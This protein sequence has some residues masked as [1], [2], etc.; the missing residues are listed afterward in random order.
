MKYEVSGD[1]AVFCT[2]RTRLRFVVDLVD[3]EAVSQAG[4]WSV[5]RGDG[6]QAH[7]NY[8]FLPGKPRT[9]LHRFLLRPPAGAQIDHIDGDGLNNRR[10]NLR[11]ASAGDNQRNKAK[12]VSNTSGFKGVTW[13]KQRQK[14][15][16]QIGFEGKN[17]YLGMFDSV[18]DAA[19]TYRLA[20][21]RLH[22]AFART[23]DF[24][25]GKIT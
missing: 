16:A 11:L 23:E 10:D 20:A 4:T 6:V 17:L 14:W 18:E 12:Y 21:A 25:R 13:S 24:A 7:T 19:E 22:G 9:A 8:V 3:A 5:Q 2:V 15:Q 1:V